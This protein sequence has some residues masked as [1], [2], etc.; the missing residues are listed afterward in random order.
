MTVIALICV[1]AVYTSVNSGWPH[2]LCV[3]G[4]VW[5]IGIQKCFSV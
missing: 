4:S 2:S 5:Y 1:A 3:P